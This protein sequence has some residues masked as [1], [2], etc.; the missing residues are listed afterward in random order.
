MSQRSADCPV[1]NMRRSRFKYVVTV[2]GA[3]WAVGPTADVDTITEG[4]KWAED[5]GDTADWATIH[6]RTGACVALHYRDRF[7][8]VDGLWHRA[9]V[10]KAVAMGD[11]KARPCNCQTCAP[12]NGSRDTYVWASRRVRLS[13]AK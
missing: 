7:Y 9:S 1:E 2:G 8:Q 4:R 3:S 10:K 5:H 11:P 13:Q 12:L 6:D